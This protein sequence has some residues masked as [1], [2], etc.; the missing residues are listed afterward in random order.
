MNQ[1]HFRHLPLF[2]C[3]SCKCFT[4]SA[5]SVDYDVMCVSTDYI[6]YTIQQTKG[7]IFTTLSPL[8]NLI[9]FSVI[10]VL[11]VG[12]SIDILSLCYHYGISQT[13]AKMQL[14]YHCKHEKEIYLSM[15]IVS[16]LIYHCKHRKEIYLFNHFTTL[17]THTLR[18]PQT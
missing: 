13:Y 17:C 15:D 6:L 5:Y 4:N 9:A 18:A 8:I 11:R 10:N 1:W 16:Q 12:L 14:I 3:T 7:H 2:S